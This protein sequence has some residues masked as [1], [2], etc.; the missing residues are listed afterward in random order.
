MRRNGGRLI[1]VTTRAQTISLGDNLNLNRH[2]RI[3][4]RSLSRE[5]F[6]SM[7]YSTPKQKMGEVILIYIIPCSANL[8]LFQYQ[9]LHFIIFVVSVDKLI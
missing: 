1:T 9:Y 4:V 7:M 3:T 5:T 2:A 8:R 6:Q